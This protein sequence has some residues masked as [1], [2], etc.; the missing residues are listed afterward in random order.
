MRSACAMISFLSM[1]TSGRSTSVDV[2]A[3]IVCM[4]SSVCDET[5]PRLSPVTSD[6]RPALPE[7]L[8]DP[9]HHPTIE[10]DAMA[11]RHARHDLALDL[12]ERHHPEIGA[13]LIAREVRDQIAAPC[14]RSRGSCTARR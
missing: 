14:R 6:A 8:G 1:P 13:Q 4:F 9:Q 5:C 7:R 2:A 3:A 10:H 12:A 11:A